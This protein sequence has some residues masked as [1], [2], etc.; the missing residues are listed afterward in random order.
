LLR[1]FLFSL[2]GE[3]AEQRRLI[4]HI[5]SG[6]HAALLE[7]PLIFGGTSFERR[8][9]VIKRLQIHRILLRGQLLE[10]LVFL[11]SG[12]LVS[13]KFGTERVL[14][15][16]QGLVGN[17]NIGLRCRPRDFGPRLLLRPEILD[18][19]LAGCRL[20]FMILLA[21][22]DRGRQPPA[23][24]QNSFLGTA[25][26]LLRDS[27]Q[28]MKLALHRFMPGAG[29]DTVQLGDRLVVIALDF[30]P[31]VRRQPLIAQQFFPRRDGFGGA[32]ILALPC[33]AIDFRDL[34]AGIL[35]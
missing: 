22:I 16:G 29:V 9:L 20:L 28:I 24:G 19:G 23:I 31:L 7:S 6:Q 26:G 32:R 30:F 13:L 1:Q 14:G 11:R 8:Q 4:E 5:L 34:V 17:F 27:F 18:Q 12:Y 21:G 10:L 3:Q 15:G 33:L 25:F 35:D 2:L